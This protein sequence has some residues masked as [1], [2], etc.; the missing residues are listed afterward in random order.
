MKSHGR[1]VSA[2]AMD[3]P[4]LKAGGTAPLGPNWDPAGFSKE[5][6]P[7]ALK[8]YREAEI[9]H[10]RLAMLGTLGMLTQ[11]KLHPLFGGN[12]PGPSVF[13]FEEI[14]KANPA[15]WYPVMLSIAIAELGR[16]RLGWTSPD[17][18]LWGLQD[19][20]DPGNLGFDPLGLYPTTEAEQT[21]MKNKELNNG[22]LAMI[23]AAGMIA[24][25]LATGQK[26]LN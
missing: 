16:A 4:V 2:K 23:A 6:D 10:G 9:T 11:E 18:S 19:K 17:E 1:K 5:A 20:Y 3:S 13:H 24:Q 15:F 14:Q 8:R 21:N 7:N 12:F 25:E 22:R 26:M